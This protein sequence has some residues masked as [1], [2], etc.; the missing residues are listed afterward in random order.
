MNEDIHL[1][2]LTLEAA[3]LDPK[4]NKSNNGERI[5]TL[6]VHEGGFFLQASNFS[7]SSIVWPCPPLSETTPYRFELDSP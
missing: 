3:A 1:R 2:N 7:C 5:V 4:Q 6:I